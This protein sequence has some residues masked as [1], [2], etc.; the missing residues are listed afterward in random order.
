MYIHVPLISAFN[1]YKEFNI[2]LAFHWKSILPFPNIFL[3]MLLSFS[4]TQSSSRCLQK[5]K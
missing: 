4:P 3:Y 1:F 5:V 2:L